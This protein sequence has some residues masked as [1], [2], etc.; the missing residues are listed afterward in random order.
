MPVTLR[1]YAKINLGLA[2]GPTRP[3]GFHALTTLYQTVEA[4]DLVTVSVDLASAAPAGGRIEITSNDPRVPLDARNTVWKMLSAAL[5]VAGRQALRATVHI[6][7]RLPV[8]GGMGGGSGNAA[9]ALV[10]LEREIA[11]R[12]LAPALSGAER[13]RMAAE[14]GSDVPL[15]LLG[16][17]V[18]GLGRGEEVLPLAD[19]PSLPMVVALPDR[20]VSTPAA[21]RAWDAE[22]AE[23]GLT[24]DAIAGR[25]REL[26]RALAAAWCEQHATGVFAPSDTFGS[27]NLAGSLLSTLVQTGILLNDFEQVVFRQHPPLEQIKR[28]LAGIPAGNAYVPRGMQAVYSALSGSGSAVFGLYSGDAEAQAAE[29][30]LNL[31]GTRSLRTR[32]LGRSEYWS[33]MVASEE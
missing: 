17:A 22:Q 24:P 15:F 11:R 18:L 5:A 3:D 26:S 31:L 21:F 19:L 7:K 32:T 28:A 9:A 1:S 13:L 6:D 16:G 4:H 8:Q 29:E 2:I 12:Q 25:L 27:E 14:V 30:R 23:R 10:G 20:G 33:G